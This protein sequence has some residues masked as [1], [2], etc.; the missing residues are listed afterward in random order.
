MNELT[1]GP[2]SAPFSDHTRRVLSTARGLIRSA[3]PGQSIVAYD[4]C[5]AVAQCLAPA[6]DF[7]IALIDPLK[8]TTSFP[9][10]L[11]DGVLIDGGVFPYGGFG[12]T[13]WLVDNRR[14]YVFA[15]DAGRLFRR[16]WTTP[17]E[18][19]PR[20]IVVVPLLR[21]AGPVIG[22]LGATSER[23]EVFDAEFLSA[24]EWLS[25]VLT[26]SAFAE[27][28]DDE[29][30][31]LSQVYPDDD[32][33]PFD[34]ENDMLNYLSEQL[35]VLRDLVVEAGREQ[36]QSSES[37]QKTWDA[38]AARCDSLRANVMTLRSRRR[39]APW[40]QLTKRELEIAELVV[41]EDLS[42][43]EIGR[44]LSVGEP[45]VKTHMTHILGKLGA[46]H[47]REL[48]WLSKEAPSLLSPKE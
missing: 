7:F 45:T 41:A 10:Y 13:Q 25:K 12:L 34:D 47:R 32:F 22:Y 29:S 18:A 5:R 1:H 9:Y 46:K 20:D 23:S 43:A 3:P 4:A 30:E 40:D 42:N 35:Y 17:D 36:G 19:V 26:E 33:R 37:S 39:T 15:H 24:L 6:D 11:A 16:G 38:I 2:P 8:R 14:S 44:R 48:K 31:R 28:S 21:V 27:A